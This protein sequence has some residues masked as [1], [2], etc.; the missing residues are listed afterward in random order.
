MINTKQNELKRIPSLKKSMLDSGLD[1]SLVDS[2]EERA[3]FCQ[4]TFDLM[5]LWNE[6]VDESEKNEILAVIMKYL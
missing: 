5:E 1:P 4:G 6:E 3:K 2:I